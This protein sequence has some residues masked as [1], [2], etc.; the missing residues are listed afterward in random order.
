M[1]SDHGGTPE[2]K[3]PR[4]REI[5]RKR[6]ELL[7][8]AR[9]DTEPGAGS[10]NRMMGLG[11][12]FVVAVLLCLYIGQWLDK[13]FGTTPWL[14]LAGTFVGAAAGF[15]SLYRAMLDENK[16]YDAESKAKQ[17]KQP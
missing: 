15:T 10:A 2:A 16:R 7:A 17:E 14:L 9:G 13:K 5:E 11:I 3:D 1:E 8:R 12:Q 6:D 4:R